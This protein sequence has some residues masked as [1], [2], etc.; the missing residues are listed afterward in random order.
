[1]KPLF[2]TNE[3]QFVLYTSLPL[4]IGD[5]THQLSILVGNRSESIHCT[6]L[7]FY[8]DV[9]RIK[10]IIDSDRETGGMSD[11]AAIQWDVKKDNFA[12]VV[13]YCE[14]IEDCRKKLLCYSLS[15]NSLDLISCN[16]NVAT[17]C[18]NCSHLVRVYF[19][20]RYYYLMFN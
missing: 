6:L 9:F 3:I 8:K 2:N 11:N 16:N 13:S 19:F 5:F 17:Q 14:N 10:Q 15:R 7:Y 1:M 4:S 12:K 20:S 18:S